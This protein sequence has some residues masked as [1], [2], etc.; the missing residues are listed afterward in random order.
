VREAVAAYEVEARARGDALELEL[1]P[2]AFVCLTDPAM[3]THCVHTLV[4][5]AVRFTDRGRVTV[6]LAAI[7]GRDVP[8]LELRIT[9]T[10]VGIAADDLPRLFLAFQPLD[11]APTRAHEG[12]GVSLA[13]A[14]RFARLLGG[15][16][17]VASVPGSGS[18][19][20][21]RLPAPRE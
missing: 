12:S 16:I 5:N 21:L 8:W 20:V 10:G 18:T 7:G 19:F 3:F 2:A 15:D 14:H 17:D 13:L 9:D 11:D 6:R 1:D 4:D